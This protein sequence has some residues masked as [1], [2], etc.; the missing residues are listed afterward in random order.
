VGSSVIPTLA[1]LKAETRRCALRRLL[2]SPAPFGPC[3][4]DVAFGPCAFARP[5][6]RGIRHVDTEMSEGNKVPGS[7]TLPMPGLLATLMW[8]SSRRLPQCPTQ[9]EEIP[10]GNPSGFGQGSSSAFGRKSDVQAC[11]RR[12]NRPSLVVG[13]AQRQLALWREPIRIHA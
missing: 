10:S 5:L 7:L 12:V 6:S 1:F 9:R 4:R 3:C 11:C 2:A 8:A 13:D